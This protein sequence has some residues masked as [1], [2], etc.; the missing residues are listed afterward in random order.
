MNE[1]R[2]SFGSLR[3]ERINDFGIGYVD[4][5]YNLN[6][7]KQTQLE[8]ALVERVLDIYPQEEIC[9]VWIKPHDPLSNVVRTYEAGVFPEAADFPPSAEDDTLLLALID[10]RPEV[11]RIIHG[12]TVMGP[13]LNSIDENSEVEAFTDST[14]FYM[15]DS[16][17][18]LD[19]FSK[20]DFYN[21][22]ADR[23]I[24]TN[25]WIT[26][27][28]NYRIGDR[29]ELSSGIRP[30]ALAYLAMF[31]L[32][33]NRAEL[34][35]E[36]GGVFAAINTPT[37]KSFAA[38][39]LEFDSLMGRT[40]FITEEALMGDSDYQPVA[41]PTSPHNMELFEQMRTALPTLLF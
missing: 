17:I 2:S 38:I 15:I 14:G 34:H 4:P 19:N 32:V 26:V 24:D 18:R 23:G 1:V 37:R 35:Q 16:L 29:V 36:L 6:P 5:D 20:R 10:T 41:I 28:S 13:G 22:H 9:A 21:Y 40:D 27:E 33:A 11:S 39:G 8:K 7:D 31:R 25:K 30:T 12:A 3:S